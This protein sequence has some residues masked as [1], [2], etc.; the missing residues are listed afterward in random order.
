VAGRSRSRRFLHRAHLDW[1]LS[2]PYRL[3]GP[4]TTV[5]PLDYGQA[6]VRAYFMALI[7]EIV[8]EYKP[9]A[10]ELDFMR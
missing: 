9:D 10:L 5:H 8:T 1:R 6:E 3:K 2:A 7:R 4:Y